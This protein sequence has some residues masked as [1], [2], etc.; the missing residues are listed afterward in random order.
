MTKKLSGIKL[1]SLIWSCKPVFN[2]F[3]A[4]TTVGVAIKIITV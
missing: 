1:W 4:Q 2:E 3:S